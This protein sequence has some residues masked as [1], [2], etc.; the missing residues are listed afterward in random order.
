[1]IKLVLE[2]VPCRYEETIYFYWEY[3]LDSPYQL[4]FMPF[5]T[6]NKFL[7]ELVKREAEIPES[8]HIIFDSGRIKVWLP[9][10]FY[11]E[12]LFSRLE[13]ILKEEIRTI[14]EDIMF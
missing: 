2:P 13:E 1:M 10:T 5:G 4:C 6:L 7:E 14:L 3:E 12:R 8:I 9:V 11:S